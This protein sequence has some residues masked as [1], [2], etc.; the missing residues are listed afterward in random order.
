MNSIIIFICLLQIIWKYWILWKVQLLTQ[1][2]NKFEFSL[3]RL[4]QLLLTNSK[5]SAFCTSFALTTLFQS[6]FVHVVILNINYHKSACSS[7][8]YT[9]LQNSKNYT[10]LFQFILY[11][12][13]LH[14]K[15][16]KQEN[17]YS[18]CKNDNNIQMYFKNVR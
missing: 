13:F 12:S 2:Y 9:C 15:W 4:L 7:L 8:V 3:L 1:I 17:I 10:F 6:N 16:R 18:T 5:D 11:N 14:A